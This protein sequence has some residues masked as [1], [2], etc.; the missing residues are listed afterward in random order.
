MRGTWQPL[1]D[2]RGSD[3]SCDASIRAATGYP[4]GRERLLDVLE[5]PCH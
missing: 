2:G 3:C 5:N 1:P 4:L